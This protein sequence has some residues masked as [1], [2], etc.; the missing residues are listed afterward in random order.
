MGTTAGVPVPETLQVVAAC[1]PDLAGV[2]RVLGKETELVLDKEPDESLG[3][4]ICPPSCQVRAVLRGGPAQRAGGAR[5]MGRTLTHIDGN[6]VGESGPQPGAGAGQRQVTLRFAPEEATVNGMPVWAKAP[7]CR[8]YSTREGKWMITDAGDDGMRRNAGHLMTGLHGGLLPGDPDPDTGGPVQGWMTYIKEKGCWTQDT[9]VA[10]VEVGRPAFRLDQLVEARHEYESEEEFRNAY[11]KE[12]LPATALDEGYLHQYGV[13][14]EGTK[15]DSVTPLPAACVRMHSAYQ[16][17]RSG[18]SFNALPGEA[19]PPQPPVPS[20][21]AVPVA[22][23]VSNPTAGGAIPV[24]QPVSGTPTS[25]PSKSPSAPP[26]GS[27]KGPRAPPEGAGKGK[28]GS[29][30]EAV[31]RAVLRR[32]LEEVLASYPEFLVNFN[33]VGPERQTVLRDMWTTQDERLFPLLEACQKQKNFE[34][35]QAADAKAVAEILAGE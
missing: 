15:P 32:P 5:F 7:K 8:L 10:V 17:G 28:V 34:P 23:A 26:T 25:A 21:A 12:V 20:P 16:P 33:D 9:S 14:F 4:R 18:S 1:R 13:R 3:L 29:E 27:A 35:L 22:L 19:T 6:P 30:S 11:I 31:V 2:Y 24:A